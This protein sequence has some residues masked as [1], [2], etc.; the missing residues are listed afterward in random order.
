MTTTAELIEIDPKKF[1]EVL[2]H[3]PTGVAVITAIAEDEEPLAMVVG[4]FTSVSLD[5]PLVA[6]LP[7]KTSYTYQRIRNASSFAVNILAQD[8]E[9]VCRQLAQSSGDKFAGLDWSP[10]RSG[11]PIIDGV[12]ASLDCE[13]HAEVEGGD[14]WIV[15]GRVR[16]LQVHRP[17][18]PLLFFQGGY[19]G[20][21]PRSL[22]VPSDR[23]LA[24][25]VAMAHEAR[26]E[27]EV[28]AEGLGVEVTAY[29]RIGDDIAAVATVAGEGLDPQAVLGSRFP[30]M[31]PMGELFVAWDDAEIDTWLGRAHG[32]TDEVKDFYR[33]RLSR[34]REAGWAFTL[35]KAGDGSSDP[36]LE[37]FRLYN[38]PSRTPALERQINQT[39]TSAADR[40]R[41]VELSDEESFDIG[42]IVAPVLNDKG[43]VQLVLRLTQLPQAVKGSEV[44][45]WAHHLIRAAEEA[46]IRFVAAN[47]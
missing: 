20:F 34:T 7:T 25:G 27:M 4:T 28:L 23:D 35:A 1:R 8:Q 30:L 6:F 11:A 13:F 16:D 18:V 36:I 37:A 29:A 44:Q 15:L 10:A 2:G 40:Y 42:S 46:S 41:P 3:Y 47:S 14:H 9:S 45:F 38:D 5:P 33:D 26:A 32:L 24:A 12:V 31:P 43:A 21:T 17:V 22:M 19:G 39:L